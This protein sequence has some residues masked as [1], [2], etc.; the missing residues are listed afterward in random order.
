MARWIWSMAVARR[1]DSVDPFELELWFWRALALRTENHK[2]HK[3]KFHH[4]EREN[5]PTHLVD[6]FWC[7]GHTFFV[8]EHHVEQAQVF[9][10]GEGE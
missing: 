1:G 10:G 3:W 2:K 6:F 9:S 7:V 4:K 8:R 5:S